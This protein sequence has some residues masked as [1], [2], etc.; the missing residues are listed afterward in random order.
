VGTWVALI[1]DRNTHEPH[2]LDTFHSE[3]HAYDITSMCLHNFDA[4]LNLPFGKP[5]LEDSPILPCHV[6]GH[7]KARGPGGS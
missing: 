7:P 1:T 4:K 6:I 5:W 3:A 2:W